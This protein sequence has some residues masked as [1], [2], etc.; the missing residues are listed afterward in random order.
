M[1]GPT[2]YDL[3]GVDRDASTDEIRAA[4]K[5]QVAD[6]D[7]TDRR[8]ASLSEAAA[9]LLDDDRRAAYDATLPAPETSEPEPDATVVDDP[10]PEPDT[11]E[12]DTDEADTDEADADEDE[13]DEAEADAD[14]VAT[15]RRTPS[16]T[17]LAVVAVVALLL[18]AAA[19]YAWTRPYDPVLEVRDAD[20]VWKVEQSAEDARLAAV[21]AVEP[22][23]SYDHRTLDD[24]EAEALE[25]LTAD[26]RSDYEELFDDVIRPNATST[27]AV[28][29]AKVVE[30]GVVRLSDDR[31]RA[32]VL[33]FVDRPTTNAKQVEPVVFSDQ[34]T[35]TMELVDGEWLVDDMVTVEETDSE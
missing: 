17:L 26:Y 24:D 19:A 13:A 35:V 7:P 12:A 5:A 11:D 27:K 6:L 8:F 10:D 29:Q 9:V 30:S 32:Q 34:V 18:V 3:L 1:T 22:V 2:W 31:T 33:I 15:A 14:E 25:H 16:T 23:L 21:E 4:W 28:V 20:G